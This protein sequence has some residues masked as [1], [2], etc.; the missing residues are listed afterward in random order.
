MR[1]IGI[2]SYRLD[3][4]ENRNQINRDIIQIHTYTFAIKFRRG[5]LEMFSKK[6][7]KLW[8]RH[9]QVIVEL[10]MVLSFDSEKFLGLTSRS[11]CGFTVME[12]LGIGSSNHQQRSWRDEMLEV[13]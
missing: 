10:E 13:E 5:F 8:A 7:H 3:C 1:E 11:N 2:Q 4:K 6:V 9:C 12:G